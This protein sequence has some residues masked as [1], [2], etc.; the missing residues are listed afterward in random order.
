MTTIRY[1]F[2]SCST[3]P[4]DYEEPAI[5]RRPMGKS[6]SEEPLSIEAPSTMGADHLPHQF[7][8]IPWHAKRRWGY[9]REDVL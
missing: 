8:P 4:H 1:N 7:P 6:L 2:A 5:F 9:W 3:K